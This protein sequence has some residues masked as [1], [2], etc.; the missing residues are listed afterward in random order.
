[1]DDYDDFELHAGHSVDRELGFY[2]HQQKYSTS[3]FFSNKIV[4]EECKIF[5]LSGI[6]PNRLQ[7]VI[8]HELAHDMMQHRFPHIKKDLTREGFAEFIASEYN[9]YANRSNRNRY[10]EKNPH[11]VYGDGYRFFRQMAADGGWQ[12]INQFLLHAT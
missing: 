11:P 9:H 6:Y 12:K 3:G 2:W 8:A 5:L 10:F 4:S 1:M 7:E